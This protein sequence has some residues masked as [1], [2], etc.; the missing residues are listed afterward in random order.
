MKKLNMIYLSL[1]TMLSQSPLSGDVLSD[2]FSNAKVEGEV[3]LGFV[4]QNNDAGADN[5]NISLGG[6]IGIETQAI[7][8]MSLGVGFYTTNALMSK[9]D[10]GSGTGLFASDDKSFS[11]LGEAYFDGSFGNSNIKIG[12]QKLNTPYTN[13]NDIRMVPNLFEAAVLTNTDLKDTTLLA[14]HITRSAGVDSPLPEEFS[15]VVSGGDGTTILG[16]LYKGV[17]STTLS[18]WYND[19][20]GLSSV[21]HIEGLRDIKFDEN[22]NLNVK[23]QYANYSEQKNSLV[24][25]Q[26]YGLSASLDVDRLNLYAGYNSASNDSGKSVTNFLGGG[27]PFVTSMDTLTINKLN[28][29]RAYKLGLAYNLFKE[30][31]ISYYYGSFQYDTNRDKEYIEQDIFMKY[32]IFNN[33]NALLILTDVK[34]TFSNVTQ[35]DSYTRARGTLSFFF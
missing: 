1:A 12:R 32:S 17:P 22:I 34:H 16:V 13:D 30:L 2:A 21:T 23:A 27:A 5:K 6:N 33:L 31:N 11:I 9:S 19:M 28:D 14:M 25:G 4:S 24:D 15:D 35:G 3:R 26:M 8:G 18:A 10:S 29:A 7:Y 20:D